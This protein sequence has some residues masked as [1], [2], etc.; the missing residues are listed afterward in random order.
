MD[1]PVERLLG[2]GIRA[3][4]LNDDR[5]GRV[6]DDLY[7]YDIEELYFEIA[8]ACVQKLGLSS[9]LIHLDSTSFH[10]DGK[11]SPETDESVIQVTRG[12][13]R[14]H[15]PDLNPVVL[16][17]MCEQPA[18]LPILMQSLSGNSSDSERAAGSLLATNSIPMS[19]VMRRWSPPTRS[20][21]RSNAA[22]A[23]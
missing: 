20:S 6:L 5:L 8:H 16:Q 3:E 9:R 13:S 4:H 10:T 7:S 22:F 18:G 21:R 1:K 14:D 23:F 19:S 15:R 12:Y 2:S 11:A 17:L